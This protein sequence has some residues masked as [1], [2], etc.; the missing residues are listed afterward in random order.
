MHRICGEEVGVETMAD[1]AAHTWCL[2]REVLC[3]DDMP[4]TGTLRDLIAVDVWLA[5][6]FYVA[7]KFN[8]TRA[9]SIQLHPTPCFF[10][11]AHTVWSHHVKHSAGLTSSRQ[12]HQFLSAVLVNRSPAAKSHSATRM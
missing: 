3:D 11:P 6:G 4:I 10:L 9:S 8:F 5:C 7:C 2:G 12:P 1:H